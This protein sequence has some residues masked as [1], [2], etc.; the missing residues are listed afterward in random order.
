[1]TTVNQASGINPTN[2]LTG[3][4]VAT[5]A[6]NVSRVL[7]SNF[8]PQYGDVDLWSAALPVYVWAFGYILPDHANVQVKQ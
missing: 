3:A 8:F 2:K 5:L 7:V 4:V 6:W 1:M